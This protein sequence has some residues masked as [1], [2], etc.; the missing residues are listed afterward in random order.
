MPDSLTSRSSKEE[1]KVDEHLPRGSQ[2]RAILPSFPIYAPRISR[3]RRSSF[4]S[5]S[6]TAYL[7][8]ALFTLNCHKNI[9]SPEYATG[10]C[11]IMFYVDIRFLPF[12]IA[13]RN[14]KYYYKF[15][16]VGMTKTKLHR[17]P[18]ALSFFYYFFFL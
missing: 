4:I 6:I 2:P 11:G 10:M 15:H 9:F 14:V 1:V 12:N 3:S 16:Y 8:S 5:F 18:T 17:I 13:R 7:H